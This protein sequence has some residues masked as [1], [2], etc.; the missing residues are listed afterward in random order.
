MGLRQQVASLRGCGPC[1]Y[2]GLV[3]FF[4]IA[5]DALE[6]L[7]RDPQMRQ[8]SAYQLMYDLLIE[9]AE[10]LELPTTVIERN[11]YEQQQMR[12]YEQECPEV[13]LCRRMETLWYR[14][15]ETKGLEYP[16][17]VLSTWNRIRNW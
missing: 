13:E 16:R 3:E 14:W 9:P 10:H 15:V 12:R 5:K 6:E 17:G 1:T 4:T 2:R 11:A 8:D 7:G